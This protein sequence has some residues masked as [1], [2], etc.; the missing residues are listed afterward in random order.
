MSIK[1]PDIKLLM[2]KYEAYQNTHDIEKATELIEKDAQFILPDGKY[3]GLTEIKGAFIKQ[4][5]L[6]EDEVFKIRKLNLE[7]SDDLQVTCRYEYRWKGVI[8]GQ[9]T[10]GK[11]KG[12]TIV[13]K[14]ADGWKIMFE[15]R[16]QD[17]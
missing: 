9:T 11:G 15:E 14:N 12:R 10:K 7:Q 4:W 3:N 17:L 1:Q 6:I 8:D 13:H 5:E 16:I 2:K